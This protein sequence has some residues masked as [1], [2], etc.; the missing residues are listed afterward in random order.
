M[1]RIGLSIGQFRSLLELSSRMARVAPDLRSQ[2]EHLARNLCQTVSACGCYAWSTENGCRDASCVTQSGDIAVPVGELLRV[3]APPNPTDQLGTTTFRGDA[4]EVLERTSHVASRIAFSFRREQDRM[5]GIALIR[6][7]NRRPFSQTELL[8][9]DLVVGSGWLPADRRESRCTS[10]RQR[11]LLSLLKAG[12]S[13]KEAAQKLN[14]SIHTVHVY[15]K[16][17]YRLFNVSSRGELLSLWI[18]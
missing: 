14:I 2:L 8:A 11:E 12:C 18:V 16:Q 7:T 5:I 1:A 6:P 15:T 4:V 17:I 3:I 13:E 9:V 10:S